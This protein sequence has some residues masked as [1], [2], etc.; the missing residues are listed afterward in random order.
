MNDHDL[1]STD[2]EWRERLDP[3]RLCGTVDLGVAK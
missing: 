2:A 3:Q 1:P